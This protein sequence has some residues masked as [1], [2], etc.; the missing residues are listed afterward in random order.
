MIGG[1]VKLEQFP[2]EPL[3]VDNRALYAKVKPYIRAWRTALDIG[4]YHGE[5]TR[6]LAEDFE[7]VFASE[8]VPESRAAAKSNL[9]LNA[10]VYDFGLGMIREPVEFTMRQGY[11]QN[12]SRDGVKAIYDV[13]P[14]DEVAPM[15]LDFVKLDVDGSE[16]D[17]I[18][19]GIETFR[20]NKPT[21]CIEVKLLEPW[22]KAHL[23]RFLD[24]RVATKV[25]RI[26]EVW[27]PC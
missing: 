1:A 21:L 20:R 17:V 8:V 25:S 23:L 10:Y 24:Y 3:T 27:V 14:L 6:M 19:G 4:A 2:G 12:C 16:W 9:P 5:W 11:A 22:A 18:H 13:V 7:V 15:M 26:D